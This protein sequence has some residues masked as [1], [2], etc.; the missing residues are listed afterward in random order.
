MTSDMDF[1]V[2]HV[3]PAQEAVRPRPLS[4]KEQRRKQRRSKPKKPAA[5]QASTVDE[6]DAIGAD[7]KTQ[8]DDDKGVDYYA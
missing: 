4:E 3:D 7:E 8:P 1:T 2:H 6:E 5:G